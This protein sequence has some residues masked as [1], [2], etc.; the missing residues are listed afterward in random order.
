MIFIAAGIA[1][2]FIALLATDLDRLTTSGAY[3]LARQEVY[4]VM[5]IFSTRMAGVFMTSTSTIFVRTRTLP[6][7]IGFLG[8]ALAALLLLSGGRFNWIVIVFPLWVALISGCILIQKSA[9]TAV[10]M[11]GYMCEACF[12][13]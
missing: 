4:R 9:I 8:Y 1:G 2:S 12:A 6:R 3:A 5:N 13:L 11:L 10:T 7:G